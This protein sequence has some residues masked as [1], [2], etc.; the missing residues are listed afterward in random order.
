ML[1]SSVVKNNQLDVNDVLHEHLATTTV[2]LCN[3]NDLSFP[4]TLLKLYPNRNL[5]MNN[6][7]FNVIFLDWLIFLQRK[8][9]MTN[10]CIKRYVQYGYVLL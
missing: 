3:Q 6:T 4:S 8:S 2:C 5:I 7:Y 10:I 9:V 1:D